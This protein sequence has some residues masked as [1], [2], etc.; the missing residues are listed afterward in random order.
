LAGH[1]ILT[2]LVLWAGRIGDMYTLV[3]FL[4]L[5]LSLSMKLNSSVGT[6]YYKSIFLYEAGEIKE[7]WILVEWVT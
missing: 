3:S 2:F 7:V 1:P 4:N 5:L 6:Y